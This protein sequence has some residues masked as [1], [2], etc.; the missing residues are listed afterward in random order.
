MVV[1]LLGSTGFIGSQVKQCLIENGVI[2]S[3]IITPTSQ[4]INFAN[5]DLLDMD[6]LDDLFSQVD[7]VINTVGVMSSDTALSQNSK[8]LMENVHH[9]TPFKIASLFKKNTKNRGIKT[10]INLSALGANPTHKVAFVGS[11]GRG[12]KAILSLN[13]ES[14]RV[15]IARPSLVCGRGGASTELFLKLAKLPILIL[16]N[17]GN[18][19]IQPVNVVDVVQGLVNLALDKNSQNLP[20]IINFTGEKVM[21]LAEYLGELRMNVYHKNPPPILNLPMPLAKFSTQILQNFSNMISVD[22][23]TLLENGNIANNMDFVKL[24]GRTPDLWLN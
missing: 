22:S 5:P 4:Q 23:L 2:E 7:T 14:F 10:W 17:S 15:K 9:I 8:R 13:D 18:F 20:P 11:K 19:A 21:T 16:P 3:D 6:Y 1:L 12:D 24:L